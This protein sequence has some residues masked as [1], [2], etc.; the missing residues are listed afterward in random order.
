[1]SIQDQIKEFNK[2][3]LDDENIYDIIRYV[4]EIN[5]LYESPMDIE[6]INELINYADEDTCC[7]PHNMLVKYHI[8]SD[9]N[10]LAANVKILI[11]Q[12]NFIENK[13]YLIVDD[14]DKVLTGA[15]H[16]I[17]Y[18]F[19]PD[20]FKECLIRSK[21]TNTYTKYY[22]LLEKTIKYYNEYLMEYK[23]NQIN[24][25]IKRMNVNN[26]EIDEQSKR[27]DDNIKQMNDNIAALMNSNKEIKNK[28]NFINE[29][30]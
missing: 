12:Y 8:L 6:F 5:K 2:S 21:Y 24:K 3:L 1:M 23:D 7:I 20:A 25:H 15:K 11:N 13:E 30:I 10:K 28:L 17:T 9:N 16:K 22:I 27:M 29:H 18:M 26:K 14:Q 19:H 4:K